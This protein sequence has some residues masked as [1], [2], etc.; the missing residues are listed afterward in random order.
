MHTLFIIRHYDLTKV[1]EFG[2]DIAVEFTNTF[3][4]RNSFIPIS[5]VRIHSTGWTQA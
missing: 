4:G 5:D 3:T 2:D 1:E